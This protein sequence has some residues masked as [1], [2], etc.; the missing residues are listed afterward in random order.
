MSD[1]ENNNVFVEGDEEEQEDVRI[2][3]NNF[4]LF[5]GWRIRNRFN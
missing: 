4:L 3:L 1:E 5:L 2:F